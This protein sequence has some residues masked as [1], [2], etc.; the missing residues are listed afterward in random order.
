MVIGDRLWVIGHPE[1]TNFDFV[2]LRLRS[3]KNRK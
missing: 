1:G 2:E 3:L